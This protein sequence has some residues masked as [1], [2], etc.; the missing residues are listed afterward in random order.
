MES[1]PGILVAFD[2]DFRIFYINRCIG[3]FKE[4]DVIGTNVLDFVKDSDRDRVRQIYSEVLAKR[5]TVYCEISGYGVEGVDA[6]YS[7]H[8]G[9]IFKDGELLGICVSSIDI[10]EQRK[11]ENKL[12]QRFEHLVSATQGIFWEADPS[13]METTYVS[14]QIFQL[15]GYSVE[16]WL[17]SPHF[18]RQCVHPQE[19]DSAIKIFHDCLL[20]RDSCQ[21][22]YR[23]RRKCGKYLWVKDLITPVV[24]DGKVTQMRGLLIDIT[25]RKNAERLQNAHSEVLNFLFQ[26]KKL[27]EILALL[28]EYFEETLPDVIGSVHLFH[29]REKKLVYCTSRGLSSFYISAVREVVVAPNLGTCGSAVFSGNREITGDISSDE[30]W[31]DF[32]GLLGQEGLRA[33][34]SE[35]IRGS[36]G[37]ILGTF[38]VYR[39]APGV[40]DNYEVEVVS[41]VTQLAALAIERKIEADRNESDRLSAISKSKLSALGEMAAGMAHEVN[42]PLAVIMGKIDRMLAILESGGMKPERFKEDLR[43]MEETATRIAKIVRAMRFLGRDC[44]NEELSPFLLRNIVEEVLQVSGEMFRVRGMELRLNLTEIEQVSV[45]CRPSEIAQIIWNLLKNSYDSLVESEG[46]WVEIQAE[47]D[48]KLARIRIKDG[49]AKIQPDVQEKMMNPF[50]TTKRV[51]EGMGLGLSISRNIAENHGGSLYYDPQGSNNSFVFEIPL[52]NR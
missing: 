50:F 41:S 7:T 20:R 4:E 10:T 33:C 44:S 37:K 39:R 36:N 31:K 29:E 47:R 40:P 17:V 8:A 30:R 45:M 48:E 38:A 26:A 23:L 51:G 52:N 11:H 34:W 18:W 13:T 22:E 28:I 46:R 14:H 3:G 12:A 5:K 21:V 1:Q 49:G 43:V 2:L 25:Y 15:L 35:P 27:D 9:P 16:E 6:T 32:R 24:V 42:N 19:F